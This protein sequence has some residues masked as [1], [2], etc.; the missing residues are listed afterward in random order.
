MSERTLDIDEVR[1]YFI[2]WQKTF[3]HVNWA[4][5]MQIVEN[6]TTDWRDIRLISKLY[7]GQSVKVRL[8]QGDTRS[9]KAGKGVRQ[10]C[11]LSPILF[12]LRRVRN[13]ENSGYAVYTCFW[14]HNPAHTLSEDITLHTFFLKTQTSIHSFWTHNPPYILSENITLPIFFLRH[15]PPHIFLKTQTSMHFFLKP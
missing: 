8:D 3:D 15:N 6:R 13:Q 7:M 14:R 10:G 4:K 11:C 1:A 9:V 2:H 5:L 12:N